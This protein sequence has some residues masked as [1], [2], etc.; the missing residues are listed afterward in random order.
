MEIKTLTPDKKKKGF[1][2]LVVIALKVFVKMSQRKVS[3]LLLSCVA[4]D[5][6]GSEYS[7]SVGVRTRVVMEPRE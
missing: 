6:H 7:V 5:L 2:K 1:Y 3:R 4:E